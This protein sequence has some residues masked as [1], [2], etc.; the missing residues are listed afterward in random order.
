MPVLQ[1]LDV[2]NPAAV[3]RLGGYDTAGNARG[4]QVVGNLAYVADADAGLQILDVSNPAAVTRL[5][6]FITSGWTDGVQVVGNL[7]YVADFRS[8][9][10]WTCPIRRR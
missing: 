8:C 6:G 9:R 2:S 7:A 1:I 4:V 5:G 10:S 3:T